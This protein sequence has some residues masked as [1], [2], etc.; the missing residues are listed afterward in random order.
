MARYAAKNVVAAGLA[1]RVEIQVSYVIG[2][3]KPVSLFLTTFGTGKFDDDVILKA[4]EKVFD[5]TP[6][7][8]IETLKL[9]RPIYS[10]TACYGH[11]GRGEKEFTW[12]RTDKVLEMKKA[13]NSLR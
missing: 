7:G 9:R 10:K 13:I 8:I 2:V 5:F 11:F 6:R 12:E 3:V 4:V 1:D